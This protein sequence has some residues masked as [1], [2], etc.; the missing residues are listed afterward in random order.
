M[1]NL[2][3][4]EDYKSKFSTELSDYSTGTPTF[5]GF[6]LADNDNEQLEDLHSTRTGRK[7]KDAEIAN[8]SPLPRNKS[9]K[10][11]DAEPIPSIV[12]IPTSRDQKIDD[13][14]F[15]TEDAMKKTCTGRIIKLSA[16]AKNAKKVLLNPQ[17]TFP[18]E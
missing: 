3:I 5:Q 1:K 6:L 18:L 11:N 8:Q 9:Q 10:V 7:A 15:R 13:T 16:K 2:R 4:F 17:K 12:T 14:E